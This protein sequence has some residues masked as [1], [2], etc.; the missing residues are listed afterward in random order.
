MRTHW[1]YALACL[2]LMLS[3]GH[4][5]NEIACKLMGVSRRPNGELHGSQGLP[6]GHFIPFVQNPV[7]QP[8]PLLR[9]YSW[10]NLKLTGDLITAQNKSFRLLSALAAQ[11]QRAD[12]QHAQPQ[13]AQPAW[14]VCKY[15]R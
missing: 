8:A 12:G 13:G 5:M 14:R 15:C 11:A 2:I 6:G 1:P 3:C 10:C 4:S 7:L 9:Q